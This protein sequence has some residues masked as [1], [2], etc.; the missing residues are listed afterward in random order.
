MQRKLKKN[1]KTPKNNL[2]FAVKFQLFLVEFSFF[3]YT[4]QG[5]SFQSFSLTQFHSVSE[6][7]SANGIPE[8]RLL[9]SFILICLFQP[10]TS[11]NIKIIFIFNI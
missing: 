1:M 11:S 8:L 4:M 5:F 3:L 9:F 7:I 2:Q 6:H 10:P